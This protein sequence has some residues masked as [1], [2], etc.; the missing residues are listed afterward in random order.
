ML[1]IISQHPC[2]HIS[3]KYCMKS[4]QK[5]ADL[6]EESRQRLVNSLISCNF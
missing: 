2:S 6:F 3:N 4:S 5:K 1:E